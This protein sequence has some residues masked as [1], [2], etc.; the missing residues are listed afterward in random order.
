MLRCHDSIDIEASPYFGL[1]DLGAIASGY[2]AD[3]LVLSSL[4][5]VKVEMVIKR[6]KKVFEH[7]QLTHEFPLGL[8]VDQLGPMNIKPYRP[9]AFVIRQDGNHVR[10]ISLIPGQILTSS[11]RAVAPVED[12]AVTSDVGRDII[13][14]VVLEAYVRQAPL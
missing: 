11:V 5:P 8:D 2:G 6:G 7:G 13:K 12:G 4:R 1:K 9:D 10:V 14:V 3:I